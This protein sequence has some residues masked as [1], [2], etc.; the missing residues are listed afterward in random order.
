MENRG[1]PMESSGSLLP[2][3]RNGEVSRR[4]FIKGLLGG[5]ALSIYALNRLNAEV[6]R[7]LFAWNQQY[8]QDEA[9]DGVYW[10]AVAKH[11]MF[12][13]GLIMM[14]N[15]TVG[16]M[17]K[18]VFNT[19]MKYFKV[20][21]TNPYDV[22]NYFPSKVW[23]VR[24]KVA[25]FINASPDEIV[26]T[27]NTTEGMN[28]AANGLNLKPG[29][30][31]LTSE[32]EHPAGI[33]AW[34]LKAKRSGITIKGVPLRIPPKNA[35]E[36][37]NAFDDAITPKTKVIS[38]SYPIYITGLNPPLKELSQ[39]ARDKGIL[40]VVDGAHSIG[41]LNL[42]MHDLGIDCWATSPYKWMGAPTGVGV[43][44]L[45]KE[46]Q[47]QL[48]P[49]I[50]SGNWEGREGSSRFETLGQR[51]TPLIFALGEAVDFQNLIGKERIERRIKTMA[52]YLKQK[53]SEIRRARVHTPM[54]PKLSGGLTALSIKGVDPQKMVDYLKEKYNIVVRTVG[55]EE[56]NTRGIRV[57]TN[58]FV[59]FHHVDLLLE[60]LQHLAKYRA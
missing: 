46:V 50:G 32:L 21:A 44:Y 20:Q 27:R 2:F 8:V 4:G 11:Y 51:A 57:S 52:T 15:G 40:L 24:E 42:D 39:L 56:D 59:S 29:D 45:R 10:E 47:D 22:Y 43:L 28:F 23:E 37:L 16:P 7:D 12:Q 17:P 53:V 31:V 54:D 5:G 1:K 49:T 35:D 34:G 30:E 6:Y 9:P 19:L 26:I 33:G 18:P 36:I 13:D 55:R 3:K 60:G 14:N 48:L 38:I 25:R 41:M 58:I